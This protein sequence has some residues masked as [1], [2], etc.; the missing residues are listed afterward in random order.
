MYAPLLISHRSD[1]CF[2]EA[3]CPLPPIYTLPNRAHSCSHILTLISSPYSH[4]CSSTNPRVK[5]EHPIAGVHE[6]HLR[7]SFFRSHVYYVS[8]ADMTS[9]A[10]SHDPVQGL[11]KGRGVARVITRPRN[12]PVHAR[13]FF[14]DCHSLLLSA[15]V[16]LGP[17]GPGHRRS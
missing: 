7:S 8:T 5:S 13:P 17:G 1:G 9:R 15:P 11:R 10:R 3:L 16:V 14:L 12:S 2:P 6:H 4:L